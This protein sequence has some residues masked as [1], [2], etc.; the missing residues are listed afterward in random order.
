M[1]HFVTPIKVRAQT[2]KESGVLR[3]IFGSKMTQTSGS[4]KKF[5]NELQNL[6]SSPNVI[7]GLIESRNMKWEEHVVRMKGKRYS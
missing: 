5:H 1:R 6:Y 3:K 7:I 2:E 4:W